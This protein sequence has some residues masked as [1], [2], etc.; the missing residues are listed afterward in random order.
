MEDY[1]GRDVRGL[2]SSPPVSCATSLRPSRDDQ[3]APQPSPR[4]PS[5]LAPISFDYAVIRVVPRVEREEFINIE[6][7]GR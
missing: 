3:T 4:R 5:V 2:P 7:P 1:P 6:E